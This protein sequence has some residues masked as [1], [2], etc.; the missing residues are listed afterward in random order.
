MHATGGEVDLQPDDARKLTLVLRS[1]DGDEIEIVDSGGTAFA[2]SVSIGAGG[3]RARLE[4]ELLAQPPPLLDITLVQGMPKGHKMDFVIEKATEL[5]VTRVVPL[6]SQRSL[7]EPR[8]GKIE[9]WRRLAR[10]AAQQCG[11]GDVPVVENPIPFAAFCSAVAAYDLVLIPWELAGRRPLREV[12]PALLE[13]VRRVAIAIGPEG[14]FASDEIDAAA[15]A[16]AHPVSLGR[17]ILRTETAGLVACAVLR[18]A[19]SDL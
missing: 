17:R 16:G 6:L 4:R 12:L 11:R 14:G 5:G 3:V 1:R 18:Y 13:G 15:A 2:A 10:S 7:V 9:R 8:D 19:A